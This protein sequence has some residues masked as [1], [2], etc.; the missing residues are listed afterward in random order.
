MRV[1][2]VSMN[3]IVKPEAVAMFVPGTPVRRRVRVVPHPAVDVGTVQVFVGPDFGGWG[4]G[5]EPQ[6]SHSTD[7]GGSGGVALIAL[8]AAVTVGAL[9]AG[10]LVGVGL[11]VA[12][13]TLILLGTA[14]IVESEEAEGDSEEQAS[15]GGH[16]EG[17]AVASD[18][19]GTTPPPMA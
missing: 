17:D 16:S 9:A 2:Q 1:R 7:A 14:V 12:G 10:G 18:E 5:N 19:D 3:A 8:G 13:V 4:G 15:E 11:A 6:E